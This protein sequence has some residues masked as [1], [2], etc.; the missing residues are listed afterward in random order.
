MDR[1]I[2]HYIEELSNSRLSQDAQKTQNRPKLHSVNAHIPLDM[3][4][5]LDAIATEYQLDVVALTSDLL[6][7]GI[8]E[9][10]DAMP[11]KDLKHM[12][13]IQLL[14]ERDAKNRESEVLSFDAGG[15]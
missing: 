5:Q 15:T 14:A 2:K 3:Y 13:E 11:K 6:T 12:K 7:L 8:A 4:H 9:A 10:L 1:Q